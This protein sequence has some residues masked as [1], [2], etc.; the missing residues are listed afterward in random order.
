M[1]RNTLAETRVRQ[2]RSL[3]VEDNTINQRI[4]LK[5][6]EKLGYHADA[7]G[8]GKEAVRAL[9][10]TPTTSFSWTSRCP[11]WTALGQPGSFAIRFLEVAAQLE[12][13]V[14]SIQKSMQRISR[15][16]HTPG[17]NGSRHQALLCGTVENLVRLSLLYGSV[18]NRLRLGLA[19]A[20]RRDSAQLL[21]G[22]KSRPGRQ[23]AYPP[24]DGGRSLQ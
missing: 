9:E 22:G 23:R 13:D 18:A 24:G 8:N 21:R 2:A 19:Q 11:R 20:G 3:L 15:A 12:A 14:D 10:N 5:I 4:T 17:T 16:C 7:V 1:T 6:L